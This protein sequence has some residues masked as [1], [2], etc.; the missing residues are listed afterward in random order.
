MVKKN[1]EE[2]S[3]SGIY[4]NSNDLHKYQFMMCNDNLQAM[5]D[6]AKKETLDPMVWMVH[7]S[8]KTRLYNNSLP[9]HRKIY[10]TANMMVYKKNTYKLCH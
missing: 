9:I 10:D 5:I 2:V 8:K 7:V 6:I 3:F 4:D 1:P